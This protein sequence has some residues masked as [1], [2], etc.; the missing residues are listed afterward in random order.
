MRVIA[1]LATRKDDVTNLIQRFDSVLC[2]TGT[3]RQRTKH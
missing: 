1:H 2:V 3:R